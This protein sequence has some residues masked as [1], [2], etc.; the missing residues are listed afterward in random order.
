ME[1]RDKYKIV[2]HVL[3]VFGEYSS[4]YVRGF[5]HWVFHGYEV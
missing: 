3:I 5:S 2:G 4:S 1:Q